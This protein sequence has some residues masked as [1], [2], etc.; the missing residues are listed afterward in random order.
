MPLAPRCSAVPVLVVLLALVL[1]TLGPLG[2]QSG[3]I[4]VHQA[5]PWGPAGLDHK[6]T[7]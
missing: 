1:A 2:A 7:F 6:L 3:R 4:E 5:P